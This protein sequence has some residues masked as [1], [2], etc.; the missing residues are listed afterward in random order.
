M[1]IYLQIKMWIRKARR[2]QS[3]FGC[4]I[5][6]TV[7]VD[8]IPVKRG[9]LHPKCRAMRGCVEVKRSP[10]GFEMTSSFVGSSCLSH[11]PA[12]SPSQNASVKLPQ[13]H[14]PH[15][16]KSK[17][18]EQNVTRSRACGRKSP[19]EI[20]LA[21]NSHGGRGKVLL[22]LTRCYIKTSPTASNI[23]LKTFQLLCAPTFRQNAILLLLY[24]H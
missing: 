24:I 6:D 18:R 14:P 2:Q 20:L 1:S 16:P 8:G 15:T 11:H 17:R 5:G 21:E 13:L 22:P 12:A 19:E 23:H 9:S 3:P 7:Q 10:C 4:R